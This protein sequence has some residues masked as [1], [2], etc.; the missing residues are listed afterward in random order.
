MIPEIEFAI[1]KL[2][3]HS[4]EERLTCFDCNKGKL[5]GFVGGEY[6]KICQLGQLILWIGHRKEIRELKFRALA[7]RRSGY[8]PTNLFQSVPKHVNEIPG[9]SLSRKSCKPRS[10]LAWFNFVV[11]FKANYYFSDKE[12]IFA[13]VLL[14]TNDSPDPIMCKFASIRLLCVR[15]VLYPQKCQLWLRKCNRI[16]GLGV[17]K[18]N[19]KS[20]FPY[21]KNPV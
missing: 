4:W 5:W 19:G 10:K 20:K 6:Y 8:A 7:L 1:M 18:G 13:N 15:V 17:F 21:S 16:D 11:H 12:R 2:L 9:A 3:I 14:W